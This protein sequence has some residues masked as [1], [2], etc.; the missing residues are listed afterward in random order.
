[1]LDKQHDAKIFKT[2]IVNKEIQSKLEGDDGKYLSDLHHTAKFLEELGNRAGPEALDYRTALLNNHLEHLREQYE[3]SERLHNLEALDNATK[4]DELQEKI[5][6]AER[7]VCD[8]NKEIVKQRI[9]YEQYEF[10]LHNENEK[11]RRSNVEIAKKL[12]DLEYHLEGE[13]RGISKSIERMA[14]KQSSKYKAACRSREEETEKIK[15]KYKLLQEHHYQK[16]K[17]LDDELRVLREQ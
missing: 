15:Q 11:M 3:A 2:L 7:L 6:K 12:A 5:L 4:T 10:E 9:Q 13:R 1:M 16:V 14:N 8:L 17:D